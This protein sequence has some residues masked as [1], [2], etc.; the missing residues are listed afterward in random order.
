M[1]TRARPTCEPLEAR[2]L[3]SAGALPP[4]LPG[5]AESPSPGVQVT[6]AL[7]ADPGKV[8]RHFTLSALPA[9]P[10]G[11]DDRLIDLDGDR[12]LD[13]VA[14][15]R[16]AGRLRVYL[17]LPDGTFGPELEDGAGYD[18]GADPA[19]VAAA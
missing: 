10:G 4:W 19:D 9:V 5:P 11:A 18:V 14:L 17:R 2:T 16:E 12:R 1:P 13:R 15:D 8:I 6:V 3:P 7:P